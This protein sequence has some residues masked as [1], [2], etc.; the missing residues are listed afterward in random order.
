LRFTNTEVLENMKGVL[1]K[2]ENEL[3]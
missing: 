2:I 3:D 1:E